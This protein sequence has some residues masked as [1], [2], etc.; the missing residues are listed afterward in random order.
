MK[1]II[2]LFTCGRTWVRIAA[3]YLTIPNDATR[4]LSLPSDRRLRNTLKQATHA[5]VNEL[6]I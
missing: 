2:S 5:T 4:R 3:A 1:I 6:T